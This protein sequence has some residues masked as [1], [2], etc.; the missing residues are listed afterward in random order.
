MKTA[1][2]AAYLEDLF[3]ERSLDKLAEISALSCG[4]RAFDKGATDYGLPGRL[5]LFVECLGWISQSLRSGSW[6][7]F[8]ATPVARQQLML[9]RLRED[10]LPTLGDRYAE[11]MSNWRDA[12]KISSVDKWLE[13]HEA[14]IEA[15]LWDCAIAARADFGAIL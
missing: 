4:C 11:S 10:G 14:V 3:R 5:F 7:Y 6:T 13:A 9:K 1:L 12:S 8:E 15:W 2:S